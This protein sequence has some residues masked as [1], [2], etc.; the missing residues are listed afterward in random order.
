MEQ[1]AERMHWTD[2]MNPLR[3]RWNS[4]C[5]QWV[6]PVLF[7]VSGAACSLTF[8]GRPKKFGFT[9]G[10][11]IM[12]TVLGVA[13][14]GAMWLLGPQN[15]KCSMDQLLNNPNAPCKGKG[16]WFDFTED[17]W[18]GDVEPFFNQM[19]YTL[20]LAILMGANWV[21]LRVVA[22]QLKAFHLVAQ[23]IGMIGFFGLMTW[24]MGDECA[25][26]ASL[27]IWLVVTEAVFLAVA[28]HAVPS[29][30]PG[31]LPVRLVQ[32]VCGLIVV[33]Q[34]ATSPFAAS[35][36]EMT[37]GY[38]FY[39]AVG[40]TK[41]FQLGV[42][43]SRSRRDGIYGEEDG[44][45]PLMSRAWPLMI[46]LIVLF[47]P[48]TNWSYDGVITYPFQPHRID[49]C[50]YAAGTVTMM[51]ILDRTS[52]TN[53]C[54]AV[55]ELLSWAGLVLY[56]FQIV[57]I[58]VLMQLGVRSVEGVA[59]LSML[60]AVVITA[61]VMGVHRCVFGNSENGRQRSDRCAQLADTSTEAEA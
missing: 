28:A 15:E 47:A 45:K 31:W 41:W 40:C 11:L 3:V 5:R 60:V 56:I 59:L 14:N 16:V 33:V 8:M 29:R 52:R 48:S 37:V 21:L 12:F 24:A 25:K 36:K 44:V 19:W 4:I 13:C 9:V 61:I 35:F 20:A 6:I 57:I 34:M 53:P 43:M 55:P 26:P 10:K 18:D 50:L 32:Y 23:W 49:R 46:I 30:C 51:F 54:I 2:P 22:N 27:M 7:W 42:V 38:M 39:L 17:P 58:T 1:Y